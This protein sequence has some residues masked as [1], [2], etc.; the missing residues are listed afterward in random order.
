MLFTVIGN[1]LS[2]KHME[3]QIYVNRFRC[4]L[5]DYINV[6]WLSVPSD[7][8]SNGTLEKRAQEAED[9]LQALLHIINQELFA[10]GNGKRHVPRIQLCALTTFFL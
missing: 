7:L 4:R 6:H 9:V 1:S 10:I 3:T 5:N 2:H 8:A